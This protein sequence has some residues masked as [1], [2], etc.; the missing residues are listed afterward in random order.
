MHD[1]QDC[2][3]SGYCSLAELLRTRGLLLKRFE[4]K[5]SRQ[6]PIPGKRNSRDGDQLSPSN[7]QLPTRSTWKIFAERSS[8][9]RTGRNRI[10]SIKH[11]SKNYRS[12]RLRF[13]RLDRF[14]PQK[15]LSYGDKQALMAEQASA[16]AQHLTGLDPCDHALGF[17]HL[18]A[19]TSLLS[20]VHCFHNVLPQ[21]KPISCLLM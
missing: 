14:V 5:I 20:S 1:P 13:T 10:Q 4:K 11:L 3:Y 19:G 15:H 2:Q 9:C 7:P 8:N 16:L 21:Q 17:S 6:L 18:L 12:L